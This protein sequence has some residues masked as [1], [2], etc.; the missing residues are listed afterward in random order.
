MKSQLNWDKAIASWLRGTTIFIIIM[1]HALQS[2]PESSR[3]CLRNRHFKWKI[4]FSLWKSGAIIISMKSNS[5]LIPQQ[6]TE[7]I[8]KR[9]SI[10][11][12][13]LA[14]HWISRPSKPK[15][16]WR[17]GFLGINRRN[18]WPPRTA[19]CFWKRKGQRRHQL[20][21]MR[22]QGRMLVAWRRMVNSWSQSD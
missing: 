12:L 6:I 8:H 13:H 2:Q 11:S 16:L 15:N 18:R 14:S 19:T 7:Q 1:T 17:H 4:K 9:F 10:I 5:K 21:R 20:I 22:G 3:H